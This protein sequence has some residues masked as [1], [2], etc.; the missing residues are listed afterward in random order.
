MYW[1]TLKGVGGGGGGTV[2]YGL[3]RYVRREEYGFQ[4]VSLR[5]GI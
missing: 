2:M 4:A 3:K 1:T 5:W